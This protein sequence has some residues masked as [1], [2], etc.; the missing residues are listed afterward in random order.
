MKKII[1]ISAQMQNGKDTVADYLALKLNQN[2]ITDNDYWRRV[3]FAA[4]VKKVFKDNFNADDAF[5][6]KWKVKQEIPEGFKKTVRKSLQFIGDGFRE[7]QST[8][9]VDLL[10]RN[11]KSPI[12]I[13]DVRYINELIKVKDEGGINILVW[14]PGFENNDP[15]GS[16]AQIKPVME[17]FKAT[18]CNGS[19]EG[20]I[21]YT[22]CSRE[23]EQS[24][25]YID[26]FI[27]NDSTIEN[28]YKK[29]DEVLVPY[30]N[31]KL[32]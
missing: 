29:I 14:R 19:T 9:W 5:I 22:K 18:E 12:I 30:V 27:R 10:F 15:N 3:A 21:D 23:A 28:L 6:E 25:E 11:E 26:F 17:Y 2:P 31:Q 8:I 13:S 7:I 32:S 20:H 4:G 24:M 16:E 1:G